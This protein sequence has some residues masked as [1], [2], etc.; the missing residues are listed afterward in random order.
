MT[1]VN[2]FDHI[3]QEVELGHNLNSTLT[4]MNFRFKIVE[5]YYKVFHELLNIP[6]M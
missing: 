4:E 6:F 3:F 1:K 2:R 5:F